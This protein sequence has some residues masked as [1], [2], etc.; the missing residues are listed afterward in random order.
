M[1]QV[2]LY[3]SLYGTVQGGDLPLTWVMDKPLQLLVIDDSPETHEVVDLLFGAPRVTHAWNGKEG[4]ERL[5]AQP[6]F[7]AIVLDLVMPQM[8]G[9]EV[10]EK[11]RSSP[12]FRTVPVCV[13]TANRD[14]ATKALALGARDFIDKRA[15]YQELKLRVLNLVDSKRKG[16]AAGRAKTNFLSLVSHELKTPMNGILGMAQALRDDPLTPDQSR[17][18]EILELSSHKMMSL[19]DDVLRF[20]ESESPLNHLPQT[21]FDPRAVV[22]SVVER[23]ADEAMQNN[24]VVE[25][26]WEPDVPA[27]VTGLP[28]KVALVLRHLVG[29]AVKFAPGGRVSIAVGAREPGQGEAGL[30]FSVRD[31]GIGFPEG[32]KERVQ[33]PFTQGEGADTRRFGGLGLGLSIASRIVQMLGGTLEIESE[34]GRGSH[35][36]FSC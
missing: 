25:T 28:E 13:F 9:F 34:P 18:L 14:D 26:H 12:R 16:E 4:L 8:G 3:D 6:E 5:A 17:Y 19:V 29:N 33:E 20:L 35:L 2:N 23:L 1:T 27:T 24:V 30:T 15:D 32:W 21:S 10:L 7:D 11:L 22:Q 36:S 31:T